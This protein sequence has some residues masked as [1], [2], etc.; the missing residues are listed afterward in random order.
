MLESF[1][2]EVGVKSP[3]YLNLCIYDFAALP[4]RFMSSTGRADANR[5]DT[6]A[7]PARS[8]FGAGLAVDH[9]KRQNGQRPVPV[10]EANTVPAVAA[11]VATSTATSA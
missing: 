10:I 8:G 3:S 2:K 7:R 11:R 5:A 6:V 1:G 4:V 9:L